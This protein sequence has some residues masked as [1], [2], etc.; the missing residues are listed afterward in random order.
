L[1]AEMEEREGRLTDMAPETVCMLVA[2][3]GVVETL[4]LR[5]TC[6]TLKRAV[7]EV[8][9]WMYRRERQGQWSPDAGMLRCLAST[10]VHVMRRTVLHAAQYMAYGEYLPMMSA[11]RM[12]NVDVLVYL[13]QNGYPCDERACSFAA[14]RGHLDALVYL[15]GVGCPW[16]ALACAYANHND[17]AHVLAWAHSWI[18]ST[19][20]CADG[21][22]AWACANKKN[23]L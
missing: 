9:P 17:H 22:C 14:S 18:R 8:V 19:W 2:W 15:R 11:A 12:G 4:E 6:R 7:D 20:P 21:P 1:D 13:H 23:E 16:D 5:A 3:V 10:D